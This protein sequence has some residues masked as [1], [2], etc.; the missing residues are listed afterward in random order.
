ML[1]R[2]KGVRKVYHCAHA[3][4]PVSLTPEFIE[5]TIRVFQPY[6]E[7]PLTEEDAR[8]ITA[9]MVTL[10]RYLAELD[11]KYPDE[12]TPNQNEPLSAKQM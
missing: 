6:S 5:K 1:G 7:T 9:N 11:R 3:H 8:E 12:C 4:S 2:N 10:F